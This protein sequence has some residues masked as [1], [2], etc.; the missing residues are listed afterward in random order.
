MSSY[1]YHS[2][3]SSPF[4]SGLHTDHLDFL[5]H[6][7]KW[8]TS[9]TEREQDHKIK[10]NFFCFKLLHPMV[11]GCGEYETGGK[12]LPIRPRFLAWIETKLPLLKIFHCTS[13]YKH[14]PT[15][16]YHCVYFLFFLYCSFRTNIFQNILFSEEVRNQERLPVTEISYLYPCLVNLVHISMLTG[17]FPKLKK[18]K[19]NSVNFLAN[20]LF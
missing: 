13:K 12:H 5:I 16:S 18:D 11:Y 19:N 14:W 7:I 2:S 20:Y 4:L 1:L 17:Y 10:T 9:I 6:Y 8:K 15:D 3:I